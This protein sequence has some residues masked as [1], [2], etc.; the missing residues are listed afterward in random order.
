[1]ICVVF[2]FQVLPNL[3][4]VPLHLELLDYFSYLT[5]LVKSSHQGDTRSWVR[6]RTDALLFQRKIARCLAGVL[7][8]NN[9]ETKVHL[10]MYR[11][12]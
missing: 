4:A 3:L 12:A 8:N 2:F 6:T 7:F 9:F 10:A 11:I 1:M 5:Y